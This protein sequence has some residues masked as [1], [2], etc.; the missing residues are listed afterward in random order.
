MVLIVSDDVGQHFHGL[1][2]PS[3]YENLSKYNQ[4]M[5]NISENYRNVSLVDD[6]FGCCVQ[7]SR[8]HPIKATSSFLMKKSQKIRRKNCK[9]IEIVYKVSGTIFRVHCRVHP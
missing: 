4:K 2:W 1:E 8:Q 3:K 7:Y 6:N 5:S 9:K